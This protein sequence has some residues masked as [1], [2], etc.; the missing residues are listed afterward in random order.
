[1]KKLKNWNRTSH[2][3]YVGSEIAFGVPKRTVEIKYGMGS[4]KTTDIVE[5]NI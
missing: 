2:M 4:N 1:M 5:A 3:P